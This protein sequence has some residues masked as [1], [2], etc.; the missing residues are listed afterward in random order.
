MRKKKN[1]DKWRKSNAIQ[2]RKEG[3]GYIMIHY[4]F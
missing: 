4:I 1:E 2:N 3:Q